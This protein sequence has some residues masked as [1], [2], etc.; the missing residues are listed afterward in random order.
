[1]HSIDYINNTLPEVKAKLVDVLESFLKTNKVVPKS[2]VHPYENDPDFVFPSFVPHSTLA[3]TLSKYNISLQTEKKGLLKLENLILKMQNIVESA[4][5]E[6]YKL[7]DSLQEEMM[8]Q[9]KS[10]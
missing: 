5:L 8:N 2:T 9:K 7:E 10:E 4:L 3:E 6:I 1:M